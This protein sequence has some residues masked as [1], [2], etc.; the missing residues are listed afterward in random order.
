[1][2][3]NLAPHCAAP[4]AASIAAPTLSSSSPCVSCSAF[5][6]WKRSLITSDLRHP[7]RSHSPVSRQRL[8]AAVGDLQH[9]QTPLV[10]QWLRPY[11]NFQIPS[12]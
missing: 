5:E 4:T 9:P 2:Q 1:M 12:N 3:I 10:K 7:Q 6:C 11:N 8:L